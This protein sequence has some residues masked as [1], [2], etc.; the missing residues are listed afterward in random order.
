MALLGKSVMICVILADVAGVRTAHDVTCGNNCIHFDCLMVY[1][2][3]AILVSSSVCTG[4]LLARNK[5]NFLHGFTNQLYFSES[6]FGTFF[7]IYNHNLAKGVDFMAR[8]IFME[9]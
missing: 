8:E 6:D 1:E 9:R 4:A 3:P 7:N 2:L 5:Y